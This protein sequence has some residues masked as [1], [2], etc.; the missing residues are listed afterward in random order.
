MWWPTTGQGFGSMV[1]DAPNV[2][3]IFEQALELGSDA[4]RATFLEDACAAQPDVRERVE[5][6]L[7]AHADAG[8]FLERPAWDT[9]PVDLATT[10]PDGSSMPSD[11]NVSPAAQSPELSLD[12]L[13]PADAPGAL[14]RID[15]YEVVEVLGCGGMGIVFKASDT[16]LNRIVAIK[17]LAPVLASSPAA[18]QRFIR[19]AQAA[20]GIRDDHVVTIHGVGETEGLPFLVMEYVAGD[21]LQQRIDR[22][23]PL[24][25]K[26]ILRIGA[27]TAAGLAAAHAQG[28][29]HRDVKPANILLQDDVERVKITD[30]GLAR[31]VDDVSLTQ[32]GAVAGTPQYMSPEQ[33]GG[34]TVDHRTDLFSLGSVLY[35]MCTGHAPFRASTAMG[36][37]RRVCEDQPESVH[38]SNSGIP[39]WLV[40]IVDTLHRKNPQERFDSATRVAELLS[41]GLSHVQQPSDVPSPQ[42]PTFVR[43]ERQKLFRTRRWLPA[44]VAASLVVGGLIITEAT[45]FTDF[46]LTIIRIAQGDGTLVIEID[47]PGITV[48]VDGEAVIIT[49][50]GP[51]EVRVTPGKHKVT[52]AFGDRTLDEQ[53]VTVSRG[54]RDVVRITRAGLASPLLPGDSGWKGWPIEAPR[55]AIAPFDDEQAKE[56][57][58]AWAS[59]L[60]LPVD[61]VNSIGMKLRLIPPGE[62]LMGSSIAEVLELQQLAEI[63]GWPDWEI[64]E[65][66]F[67]VPKR[68]TRIEHPYYVGACEVTVRNF[69]T[70]VEATQYVT[71]AERTGDGGWANYQGS[72]SRRPEHI[73]K[74][75]GAWESLD[76]QPV[77][78]LSYRDAEA[79]CKWL[80]GREG[81]KYSLP[82]ENQWEMAS[83]AGTTNLYGISDDA[84]S[85][86][87]FAWTS[88]NM[89]PQRFRQPQPVGL[90]KANP[91]GLHD[92]LG[93]AWEMCSD[94]HSGYGGRWASRGGCYLNLAIRQRPASR[95]AA[96]PEIAWDCALS[97]RVAI[98]GE[99]KALAVK[100]KDGASKPGSKPP[101]AVK[102]AATD[103]QNSTSSPN[104]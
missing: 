78:Q 50:A 81:L 29:V 80:S 3:S 58:Q 45:G 49:G 97:F 26:E 37:L 46:A 69:R 83:R 34:E 55:P 93:N 22:D 88:A 94:A 28:L 13:T 33:A 62:F 61:Y 7:R 36:M 99:L 82:R 12:F 71:T 30:F 68:L 2:R 77:V 42:I 15:Q 8:S 1:N 102:D 92:M 84:D 74:S 16:R 44:V 103:E 86:G 39:N 4:E 40:A 43:N 75:P 9:T 64:K 6:L 17:M 91:F 57:Q 67:E 104:N 89:P 73:W 21:S 56:H 76:D 24:P 38:S 41:H 60:G 25:L 66:A 85:V 98:T 70:F 63:S 51:S 10:P 19:E 31:T 14:G 101:S 90:K 11:S 65:L 79:F 87:E 59:Y 20:A 5:A 53:M 48:K 95:G 72:W 23:G 27:Q 52:F 47:D 96:N 54:G 100:T 32:T 35:A 18:R